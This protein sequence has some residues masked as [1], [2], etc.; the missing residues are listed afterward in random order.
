MLL[1]TEATLISYVSDLQTSQNDYKGVKGYITWITPTHGYI[2]LAGGG[3]AF[4]RNDDTIDSCKN[5]TVGFPYRSQTICDLERQTPQHG[6]SYRAR[7]VKRYFAEQVN[8]VGSTAMV[9]TLDDDDEA[10]DEIV[11]PYGKN[12]CESEENMLS[13]TTKSVKNLTGFRS[14]GCQTDK[15]AEFQAIKEALGHEDVFQV[16][17]QKCPNALKVFMQNGFK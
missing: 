17:C 4:F 1:F 8:D 15:L 12:N 11:S 5:L 3:K 2:Q 7:N 16:L 6:C 10:D 14:V 13:V 9:E